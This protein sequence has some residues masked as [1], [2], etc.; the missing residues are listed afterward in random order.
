MDTSLSLIAG[1]RPKYN[2]HNLSAGQLEIPMA[3][4]K[5]SRPVE[6]KAA[7][8]HH[9]PNFNVSLRKFCGRQVSPVFM[10]TKIEQ[11]SAGMSCSKLEGGSSQV[12]VSITPDNDHPA[13]SL[14]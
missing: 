10:Q 6:I 12:W 4:K 1:G 5:L 2:A 14:D 11:K 13:L 7:P 9:L 8:E 3:F